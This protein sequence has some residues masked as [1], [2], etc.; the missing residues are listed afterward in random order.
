[1]FSIPLVLKWALCVLDSSFPKLN[2][3]NI[4]DLYYKKKPST[5][6]KAPLFD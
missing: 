3:V 6:F 4:A 5:L 2:A 1:M